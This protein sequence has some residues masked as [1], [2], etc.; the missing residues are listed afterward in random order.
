VLRRNTA[1]SLTFA[2]KM[3]LMDRAANRFDGAK[4]DLILAAKTHFAEMLAAS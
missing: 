2:E 4:R 1:E 3:E